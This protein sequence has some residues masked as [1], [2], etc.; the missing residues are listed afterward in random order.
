MRSAIPNYSKREAPLQAALAKMLDGK[1]CR[2]KKAAAAV[3]LLHLWGPEEQAA[4]KYLQALMESMRLAFTDPNKRICVLTNA[5]DRFNAGSVTQ[6]DE[7]Q[8]D[9]PAEEQDHQ[10]LAFFQVNSR[11]ATAIGSTRE[12]MLRHCRRRNRGGL[13]VAK[14]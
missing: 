5:S 14:S 1:S 10:P 9:L 7:D 13:P 8:L 4:F 12:G 2:T 6:I 3:S 11:R